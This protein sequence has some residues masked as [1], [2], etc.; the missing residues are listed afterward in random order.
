MQRQSGRGSRRDPRNRG[1]DPGYVRPTRAFR[2][3]FDL[4]DVQDSRGTLFV[5]LS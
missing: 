1:A 2:R 3:K 5:A 4:S